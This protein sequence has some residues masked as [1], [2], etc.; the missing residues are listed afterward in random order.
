[1]ANFSLNRTVYNK[2][3][4]EK[5]IDTT[6]S[7]VSTPPLPLADT[8]TVT[9]FFDLYNSIFYDIPTQGDTNSHT[10]IVAKSGD[11]IN[12]DQISEDVQA[13]LD[14]ITILRQDLLAANQQLI[15][16]Q[17]SASVPTSINVPT[18]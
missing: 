9:E 14:E 8:I 17:I 11:Y 4:Y 5:T 7:Q 16:L 18:L 2:D 6:F 1:M 10:Y 13:L 12:A 15:T 3:A